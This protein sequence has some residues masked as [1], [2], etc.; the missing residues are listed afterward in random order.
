MNATTPLTAAGLYQTDST[1]RRAIDEW[2]ENRRCDLR[3]VD[4]LLDLDM[5]PQAEACRWA[6]TEPDRPTYE[7]RKIKCGPFPTFDP[8]Y[9]ETNG[10]KQNYEPYWYWMFMGRDTMR[11]CDDV[12]M[13]GY[14][15]SESLDK[16]ATAADAILWL[17][18]NWH[19][20][21]G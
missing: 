10:T 6:A 17:I 13:S 4:Y 20:R 18:D 19:V 12:P 1:F 11:T 15:R 21:E 3:L 14:M 7:N 9:N 2:V 8:A 5:V 16:C